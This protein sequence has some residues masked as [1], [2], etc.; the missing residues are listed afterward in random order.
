[1]T[2]YHYPTWADI[3][4][5]A[6]DYYENWG[7]YGSGNQFIF[8]SIIECNKRN[9][10]TKNDTILILWTGIARIDY[11]QFN[12]WCNKQSLFPDKSGDELNDWPISSP[13][14]YEILSYAYMDAIHNILAGLNYRSMKWQEYDVDAHRVYEDTLNNI[15]YI[16]FRENDRV[17]IDSKSY[18]LEAEKLY[19]RMAG[20]DWP[21]L[22]DILSDNYHNIDD[23]FIL[24][25]IA[26]FF[27]YLKSNKKLMLSLADTIDRHPTPLAHLAV[28]RKYFPDANISLATEEWVETIDHK[29][30]SG[31]EYKFKPSNP[32][33][34]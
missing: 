31:I 16:Q 12:E 17:Y 23:N 13:D 6:Y 26:E 28:V 5:T 29:L 1:M 30:L 3:L 22:G 2:N 4:G 34:Y 32:M 21:S 11:Y 8:N 27:G 24:E 19:K 10:L 25:E 33:R 14:G 20:E 9:N 7:R 15:E 18:R